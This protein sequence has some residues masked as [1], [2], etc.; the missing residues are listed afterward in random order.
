MIN[1]EKRTMTSFGLSIGT[2]LM[3]E[4][5][6]KP[7]HER[8][9]NSRVIP[10]QIDP[11]KYAYHFINLMTMA[12]NICSSFEAKVNYEVFIKDKGF[13]ECLNEEVN[14]I[15]SLYAGSG[16]EAV[17][18]YP[19]F[20]SLEKKVNIGKNRDKTQVVK[21]NIMIYKCLK[22]LRIKEDWLV[23]G[24]IL[25][26]IEK[27][28]QVSKDKKCLLTTSFGI[29]TF[30]KMNLELLDS[31]TGVLYTKDKFYKRYYQIGTKD[32]SVFPHYEILLY[33]IGDYNMS[34]IISPTTRLA[35]YSIATADAW[36]SK[37]TSLYSV[38]RGIKSD[39]RLRP[40]FHNYKKIYN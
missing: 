16:C 11:S 39:P 17:F 23:D 20:E 26:N 40:F 12:R 10:N 30:A 13:S 1:F 21:D 25:E 29:D 2:G 19:N 36:S 3:L 27:L 32:M 33:Y 7:T 38:E 8:Y 34:M 5:I 22:A 24:N 37:T 18:Y 14:I 28:P 6:F 31:H 9:D 4:S 15:H 35:L